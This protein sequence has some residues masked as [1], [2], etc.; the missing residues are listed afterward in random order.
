MEVSTET[1]RQTPSDKQPGNS[2]LDVTRAVEPLLATVNGAWKAILPHWLPFAGRPPWS[3]IPRVQAIAG[4]VD[5]L[6]VYLNGAWLDGGGIDV[7]LA[8]EVIVKWLYSRGV[9]DEVLWNYGLQFCFRLLEDRPWL[10]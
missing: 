2:S 4:G 3:S 1:P 9:G 7:Q 5:V 8:D 10:I 6:D